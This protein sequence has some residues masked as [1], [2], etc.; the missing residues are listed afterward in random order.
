MK[1][2]IEIGDKLLKIIRSGDINNYVTAKQNKKG[3][4]QIT[5][6]VRVALTNGKVVADEE[7][8]REFV[9]WET[10]ETRRLNKKIKALKANEKRLT[11]RMHDLRRIYKSGEYSNEEVLALFGKWLGVDTE[12]R[13]GDI[14]PLLLTNPIEQFNKG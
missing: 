1:F 10:E 8:G 14:I 13:C 2:E 9:K 12:K 11:W 3:S 5:H 4:A 6:K 7:S